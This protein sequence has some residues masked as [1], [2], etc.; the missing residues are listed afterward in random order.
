M[1][2][3]VVNSCCVN[4]RMEDF[5]AVLT[6]FGVLWYKRLVDNIIVYIIYCYEYTNIYI[7]I[8][9]YI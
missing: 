7:Y 3:F 1:V 9:I 5:L 4:R 8:Y 2:H 6:F